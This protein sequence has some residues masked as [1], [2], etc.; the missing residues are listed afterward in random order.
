MINQVRSPFWGECVSDSRNRLIKGSGQFMLRLSDLRV[1]AAA[2][3]RKLPI[4]RVAQYHIDSCCRQQRVNLAKIAFYNLDTILQA[5][6]LRSPPSPV[7]Q[8]CLDLKP[9]DAEFRIPMR[10]QE[11]DRAVSAAEIKDPIGGSRYGEFRQ[12][13]RIHRMAETRGSLDHLQA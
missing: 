9:G 8:G 13:Q 3:G 4:G 7:G 6:E 10:Q 12:Q 11:S 5:V 1:R 2:P